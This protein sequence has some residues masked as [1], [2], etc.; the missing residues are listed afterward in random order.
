L[1]H[2]IK[3]DFCLSLFR[4]RLWFSAMTEILSIIREIVSKHEF[5]SFDSSSTNDWFDW[6]FFF[7]LRTSNFDSLST[8]IQNHSC[9]VCSNNSL[10]IFNDSVFIQQTKSQSNLFHLISKFWFTRRFDSFI[11]STS[12]NSSNRDTTQVTFVSYLIG[13]FFSIISISLNKLNYYLRT[14]ISLWAKWPASFAP[15]LS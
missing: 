4:F 15:I 8:M 13:G 2:F 6:M 10:S 3:L 7:I 14:Q 5:A 9:F 11:V 1:I 12:Q